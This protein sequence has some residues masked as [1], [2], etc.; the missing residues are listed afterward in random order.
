[1]AEHEASPERVGL[2]CDEWTGRCEE[3]LA[4]WVAF[5]GGHQFDLDAGRAP[6]GLCEWL[7][8][9]FHEPLDAVA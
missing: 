7:E 3:S 9:T 4:V 2:Y 5:N 6:M 1:M 8:L